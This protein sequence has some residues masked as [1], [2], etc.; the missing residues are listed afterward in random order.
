MKNKNYVI[1]ARKIF[2]MITMKKI[3]LNFIKKLKI[4]V[5][6]QENLEQLPIIFAI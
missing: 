3:N 5:F 1:Y 2:A 4:I 6:I